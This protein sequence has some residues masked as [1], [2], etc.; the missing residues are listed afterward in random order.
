MRA[1]SRLLAL[2]FV[3]F[4]LALLLA[5]PPVAAQ[6]PAGCAGVTYADVVAL[7][8]PWLWNRYGALEPQGMMY[9]LRR[10][11]VPTS[12]V[13]GLPDPGVAYTLGAGQVTLRRD[14]RPRP[15]VLRVNAGDCLHVHFTNLLAPTRAS[16]RDAQPAPRSAS[17]HFIGLEAVKGI[18][19]MGSNAG[20]NAASANGILPPNSST[21]YWLY[22]PK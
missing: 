8:Q 3:T 11:V 12:D 5:A 9:A 20:Q 15:L 10:D 7:D 13:N 17:I 21:D 16:R 19:D 4:G 18:G 6:T 22:A 14:K 2:G 1:Q